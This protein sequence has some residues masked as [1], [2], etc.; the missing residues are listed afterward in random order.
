MELSQTYELYIQKRHK[1]NITGEINTSIEK[2]EGKKEVELGEGGRQAT[3]Q[4]V[5]Y[6]TKAKAK[7]QSKEETQRNEMK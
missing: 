2:E 1:T 3:I 5:N 4:T 7:K 6:F